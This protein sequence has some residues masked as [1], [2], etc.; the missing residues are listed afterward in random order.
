MTFYLKK[1]RCSQHIAKFKAS[2]ICLPANNIEP[3]NGDSECTVGN[4]VCTGTNGVFTPNPIIN[5]INNT[6]CNSI[7][8]IL[9]FIVT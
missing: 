8:I 3:P 7:D 1:K 9:L 5:P 6:L 4:H 2:I